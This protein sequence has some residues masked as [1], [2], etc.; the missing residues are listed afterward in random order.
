MQ[1]FNCFTQKKVLGPLAGVSAI[2]WLKMRVCYREDQL[3]RVGYRIGIGTSGRSLW[4]ISSE[5]FV[6]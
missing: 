6:R 5:V 2:N 4:A 3:L 1:D